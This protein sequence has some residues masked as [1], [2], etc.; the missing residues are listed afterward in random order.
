MPIEAQRSVLWLIEAH[1]APWK[2]I[3]TH[4]IV[5]AKKSEM[6]DIDKHRVISRI[7]ARARDENTGL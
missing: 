1:Q 6:S 2:S 4:I 5:L 7:L 3:G